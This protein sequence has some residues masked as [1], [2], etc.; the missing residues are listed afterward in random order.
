M[1]KWLDRG[2][3]ER[4]SDSMA[5]YTEIDQ[6]KRWGIRVTLI[7]D[8]ARVEIINGEKCTWYKPGPE[9]SVDVRPPRWLERLRGISFDDKLREAVEEKRRLARERNGEI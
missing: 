5:V 6:G 4:P 3:W 8:W 2:R 1:I 9:I 7:R